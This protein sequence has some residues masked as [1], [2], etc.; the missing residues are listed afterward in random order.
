MNEK[1]V[2]VFIERLDNM[3]INNNQSFGTV[4]GSVNNIENGNAYNTTNINSADKDDIMDLMKSFKELILSED[5]IAVEDKDEI[6]D[7]IESLSEQIASSEPNTSRVKSIIKRLG[8]FIQ[9]LPGKL[10]LAETILDNGNN[11]VKKIAEYFN[12]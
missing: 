1:T 2:K 8:K 3:S 6:V 9:N 10:T 4:N 11:L 12:L 5:E 7:D